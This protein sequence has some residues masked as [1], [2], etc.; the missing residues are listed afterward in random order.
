MLATAGGAS[1]VKLCLDLGAE[2]GIDYRS[3]DFAAIVNEATGGEGANVIYDPVGGDTFDRS[4]KCIAWE[5]RILIIG[6]SG[7]RIAEMRT[8]HALVKNYSAIGIHMDQY[9]RRDRPYLE[10]VRM[11]CRLLLRVHIPATLRLGLSTAG[12]A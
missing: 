4:T 11:A 3:E 2:I 1:K 5:G 12:R 7:G 8:N 9:G 6:F 10:S